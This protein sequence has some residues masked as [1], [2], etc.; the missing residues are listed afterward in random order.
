MA[1]GYA[2]ATT[3]LPRTAARIRAD[4]FVLFGIASVVAILH[5]LTNNRYGFHRDELQFLSDARHLDWGYVAYPPLTSFVERIGLGLF[6][7]SLVGL[8]LFSVLSQ[9]LS[10]MVTGMMARDLGGAR[11]AEVAAAIAVATSP[12]PL[13]EGTQFQYGTF[14]YLWWVLAAWFVIRLLKTENSRYWLPIGITLGLG[15]MTKYTIGLLAIGI[16]LGFLAT[17]ARRF[18]FNWWFV[19]GVVIALLIFL[20]NLIWQIRHG[21]ISYQFLRHIHAR[22]VA[23]GRANGFL[24]KQFIVCANFY[25]APLWIFGL[26]SLLRSPRYR[27]LAAM[28]LVPFAFLFFAKGLFYYLAPAY[29]MLI[30]A[31]AAMAEHWLTGLPGS[32]RK[33][34]KALFFT[35]IAGA[36]VYALMLVVPL[37]SS[38]RL[39]NFALNNNDALRE[40]LGWS[41]LVHTVA[42]IRDSLPVDKRDSLGIVVG[43]YG[44]QGAIEVLGPPYGLPLPISTT[45]SAWLRGYPQTAPTTLIVIGY[46]REAADAAF[47]SCR[48]A[49]H[50][51]NSLG[52][53]NEE[54]LSYPEIF[55]CDGPRQPWPDFW[56]D[57]QSFG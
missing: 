20:P 56:R 14:D 40:E 54:S 52:L 32:G 25:A 9:S 12:L 57:H 17:R 51:G 8:R 30:A 15:L 47:T 3:T 23:L 6:G 45:N 10:I 42:G 2:T 26:V 22:D 5:L 7:V 35:G 34:V 11:L 50:N 46:S 21:F 16:I 36:G 44:E 1:T 43:N 53:P 55:L 18:L 49:G 48:L 31:G 38:G 33:V 39:M 13:F 19:A 37:A 27:P 29:P 4:I 41:E 28:Y 24:L